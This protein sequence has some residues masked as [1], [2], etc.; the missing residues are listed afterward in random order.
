MS[1]SLLSD[2]ASALSAT[3]SAIARAGARRLRM[4]V[5]ENAA[6]LVPGF[7]SEWCD[8]LRAWGCNPGWL[9]RRCH[10]SPDG[11]ASSTFFLESIKSSGFSSVGTLRKPRAGPV[12]GFAARP[13]S[14]FKPLQKSQI[15]RIWTAPTSHRS[16]GA[17]SIPPRSFDPTLPT[18]VLGGRLSGP[19][20]F[21]A[22]H[23]TPRRGSEFT[24]VVP[25]PLKPMR[26]PLHHR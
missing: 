25:T 9:W 17:R 4:G 24:N 22:V 16:R 26:M 15:K 1:F 21:V 18:R 5:T 20:Q 2:E 11:W 7:S 23:L 3:G 6:R 10:S 13:H 14:G 8:T 12:A 19:A